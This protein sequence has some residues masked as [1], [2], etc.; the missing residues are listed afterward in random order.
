MR[1]GEIA[2]VSGFGGKTSL[3]KGLAIKRFSYCQMITFGS[4]LS[5]RRSNV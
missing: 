5:T 2:V 4:E 3:L 1:R